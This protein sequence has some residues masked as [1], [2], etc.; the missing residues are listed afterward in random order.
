[1][2]TKHSRRVGSLIE[3][4]RTCKQ[5]NTRDVV[6]IEPEKVIKTICVLPHNAMNAGQRIPAKLLKFL[7]S[8]GD[9]QCSQPETSQSDTA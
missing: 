6:L 7:N 3:R 1:M 5:C 9:S 8:K 2:T 4:R